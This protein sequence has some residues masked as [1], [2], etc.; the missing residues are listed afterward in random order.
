[1][2]GGTGVSAVNHAQD[3]HPEFE[4]D[5]ERR[6][7][8]AMNH[9]QDTRPEFETDAEQRG[10]PARESTGSASRIRNRWWTARVFRP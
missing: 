4:T 10:R 9:A 5:A 8:P 3:A 1:M 2:P 6:E 7:R